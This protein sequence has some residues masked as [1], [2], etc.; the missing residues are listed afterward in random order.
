[1][2]L[3]TG[4]RVTKKPAA[5]APAKKV[6]AAPAKKA[7]PAKK[8][9]VKRAPLT[10]AE[11]KKIA[12]TKK[13]ILM[14]KAPSDFRP[15]YF[16]VR[17]ATQHDGLIHPN[18]KIERIRGQW[19]NPEAKRY[20]LSEYDTVTQQGILSRMQAAFYATNYTRRLPPREKFTIFF[21]VTKKSADDTLNVSVKAAAQYVEKNGK[22]KPQWF[23]DKADPTYRKIRR[24][25]RLMR[26]AFVEVQLPPSGRRPK[27]E[28]AEE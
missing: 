23:S 25:A 1:M 16:Q 13:K 6:A 26:G 27:K 14:F 2:A 3:L 7:F 17:F 11:K 28:E 10:E 24:C 4:V 9:A 5:A 19:D 21:R 20:D 15:A 12:A 8:P 18:V 22:L